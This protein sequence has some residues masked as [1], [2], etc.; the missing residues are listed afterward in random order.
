MILLKSESNNL[1]SN[2]GKFSTKLKDF[3]E[4]KTSEIVEDESL[5]WLK[6]LKY[7]LGSHKGK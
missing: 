7:S 6:K 5:N 2:S 3:D 4:K 1:I